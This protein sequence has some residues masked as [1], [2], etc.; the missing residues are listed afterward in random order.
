MNKYVTAVRLCRINK[1]ED[2]IL[3]EPIVLTKGYAAVDTILRRAAIFCHVEVNGENH[4]YFADL[5]DNNAQWV[6]SVSLDAGSFRY[7]KDKLRPLRT[8]A[9]E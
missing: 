3:Y 1:Q 6:D 4:T 2:L 9:D 8:Y 5:M 7:L